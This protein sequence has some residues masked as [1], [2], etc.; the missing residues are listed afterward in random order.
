MAEREDLKPQTLLIDFAPNRMMSIEQ[1]KAFI[2][3]ASNGQVGNDKVEKAL[4]RKMIS[5]PI[6]TLSS[7]GL[8]QVEPSDI[9]KYIASYSA[10]KGIIEEANEISVDLSIMDNAIIK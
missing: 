6:I 9:L 3:S 8:T 4:Q 7:E 1:Y 2:F 10:E 5:S